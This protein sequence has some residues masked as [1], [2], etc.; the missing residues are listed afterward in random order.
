MPPTQIRLVLAF[1]LILAAVLNAAP[2]RGAT[3]EY[4]VEIPRLPDELTELLSSVSDCVALR[5]T[6]PD[7]VGL[8]RKRMENDVETFV[9]TLDA[10]GYFKADVG[11]ELDAQAS[12]PAIRFL[13]EPG[14]RFSFG[15]TRLVLDPENPDLESRLQPMLRD[16]DKGS[17]YSSGMV[18]DTE[19]ALLERLKELGY[20][21]PV[22][23]DRNVVAD[24]ASERVAVRFTLAPGPAAAF[25][26]TEILGLE[27][28]SRGYV[29]AD[30]AW[31]EGTPFDRRLVDKTRQRLVSSG[32]FRSVRIDAVHDGQG[33]VDMRLTLLEAPMRTLRSGLWYYSD[34]GF[35]VGAGWAHRNY[36]GAGQEL[37]LDAD[38]SENLQQA[39]SSLI[40]PNIAHTGQDLT[41]SARFS[42][43]LTDGFDSTNL[44]LSGIVRQ[45]F[46]GMRVGYGLAYRLAEVDKDTKRRFH[47]LS[48]PLIAEFS[49][50][51]H[52]LDPTSGLRLSARLEPFLSLEERG[53]SFMLWNITGRHY[54][55][56]LKDNS[57]ILATR[58]R[59]SLLAGTGRD[60][61]PE[62]MLLY[63]G[64]GG[65]I[66]GY[67][68]QYAGALDDD[69][70]PLGGVSALD[71]SVE[72][73]YR[74]NSTLGFVLFGDGGGAFSSRSP[75]DE[76]DY[77]WGVGAG[78]RYFTPIGPLR[79]DVAVPLE[80][81][82]G[83]D[84]P[85]QIY[86]SLGQA[87]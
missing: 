66:R 25:G 24:H 50:A 29:A 76:E 53:S 80:R 59:Y 79:L 1:C 84:D 22:M 35:G 11:A 51:D 48:T 87:F 81:R 5:E 20:P 26:E 7:T 43:E 2:G 33:V 47:L 52:P 74:M 16:M 37:R 64:G 65:S 39:T 18:L 3:P 23:K 12:P 45:P 32:L 42:N 58:G 28:V 69:E 72:M 71:F 9:R 27:T 46:S 85:V 44:A 54:L 56:L 75:T 38:V 31:K 57:L 10:R 73:R 6:P 63:A 30:L 34:L 67:A 41:L 8:L 13:V 82:D 68:Y 70:E 4:T 86:V 36:L 21:S 55:P 62:D 60:S 78:L 14:P 49:T 61:I 77:F 15:A 83:V 40:L 17:P 19:T